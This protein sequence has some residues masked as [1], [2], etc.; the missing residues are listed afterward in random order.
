MAL[1]RDRVRII[2]KPWRALLAFAREQLLV[3]RHGDRLLLFLRGQ[4][5]PVGVSDSWLR[6]DGAWS[7]KL[8]AFR[9]LSQQGALSQQDEQQ[10][11][12]RDGG[13]R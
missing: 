2:Q 11:H 10:H 7:R 5:V 13:Q 6:L 8:Y 3:A 12:V 1:L 4:V 9:V